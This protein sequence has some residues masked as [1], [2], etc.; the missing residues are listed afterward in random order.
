[1]RILRARVVQPSRSFIW[2]FAP[3]TEAPDGMNRLMDFLYPDGP[4]APGAEDA[5]I[6][7][8]CVLDEPV[9]YIKLDFT[10]SGDVP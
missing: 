9:K 7:A 5:N 8:N 1:M 3:N 4:L 2:L 6:S 10:L